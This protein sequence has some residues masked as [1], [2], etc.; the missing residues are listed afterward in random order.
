MNKCYCLDR[1]WNNGRAVAEASAQGGSL[2]ALADAL[3]NGQ[4]NLFA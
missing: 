3:E 4:L 2:R 1:N